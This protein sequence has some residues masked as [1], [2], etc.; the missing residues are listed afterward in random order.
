MDRDCIDILSRQPN[1]SK[2]VCDA[3]RQKHTKMTE[4]YASDFDTRALMIA[5]KERDIPDHIKRELIN[6]LFES[7]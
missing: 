1:K 6:Y 2:Y 5:L 3:I 7:L 4:A